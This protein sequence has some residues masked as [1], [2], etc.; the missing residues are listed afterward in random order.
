[1][2]IIHLLRA[3][4]KLLSWID[5]KLPD[6][7]R[8]AVKLVVIGAVLLTPV[9]FPKLIIQLGTGGSVLALNLVIG[10]MVCL[11]MGSYILFRHGMW[12]WQEKRAKKF[13][14]LNLK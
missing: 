14:S 7:P 13:I 3:L 8:L 11:L 5:G 10:G 9:A 12:K 2:E 6:R 4:I 1:M